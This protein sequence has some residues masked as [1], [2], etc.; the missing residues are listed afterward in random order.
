T[1]SIF[2]LASVVS[3]GAEADF[4]LGYRV[5]LDGTRNVLE[6]ARATGAKPRVVF[7]SSIATY[8][9]GLPDGGGGVSSVTPFGG[10][11]PLVVV[12]GGESPRGFAPLA[13]ACVRTLRC[14]SW[15][16]RES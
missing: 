8:G 10:P 5:N 16:T 2:H 3:A 14:P 4:D 9:G 13:R 7:T 11:P 12:E 6:A 1:A 15:C